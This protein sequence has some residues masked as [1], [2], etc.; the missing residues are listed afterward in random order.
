MSAAM[1]GSVALSIAVMALVL[2]RVE[3]PGR[4]GLRIA[5][6]DASALRA[7]GWTAGILRWEGYRAG[8]VLVAFAALLAADLPA[9]LAVGAGI[10]PSVWIRI[11]AEAALL[12]ARRAVTRVVAGVE[13]ALRSGATVTDAIRRETEAA[14]DP[15]ARRAFVSAL[16]AFD[17]GASLP[18]GLRGAASQAGDRRIVLVFDTLA[19]GIEERLS[20]TRIAD[21]LASLLDRLAFEERLEDEVRARASGARQ[22]QRLLALLVPAIALVLI[23]S[24]PSLATALDTDL[25]R[26]VLI[27][28]AIAFEVG[29]IVAAR[30]I[31]NEALS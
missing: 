25:G 18:A 2:A 9:V 8:A 3:H 21:L 27:P 13:A 6:P 1:V 28:G 16:R 22:Q 24:M 20:G 31:V 10:T 30:R 7:T 4:S 15:L 14:A 11:R 19:M 23:T 12:R 26:F 5:H 17:L 29:G